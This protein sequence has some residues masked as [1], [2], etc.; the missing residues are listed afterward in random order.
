ME[1]VG[2]A[3]AAKL[4][5]SSMGKKNNLCV[6][7]VVASH[8]CGEKRFTQKPGLV[9]LKL[10]STFI[11]LHSKVSYYETLVLGHNLIVLTPTWCLSP[12]NG[13]TG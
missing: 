10:V 7:E 6:I 12:G 13:S 9:F 8:S 5:F 1:L 4:W 2:Q 11:F 3:W